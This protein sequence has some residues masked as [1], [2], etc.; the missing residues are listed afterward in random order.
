MFFWL[1]LLGLV[2]EVAAFIAVAEHIGLLWAFLLLFGV[3]LLGP[4]VVRRVGIGVLSHTQQ[5]LARGE[6]P[7]QELLDG[8]VVLMGGV[9]LCV[10]GFVGDAVGLA[11]MVS[12]LRHL[13]IRLSGRHLARRVERVN[14]GRWHDSSF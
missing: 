5:R 7:T 13:V 12:P 8:L 2:A 11:L 14:L 6:L 9:L 3:S 10:P 4:F 1:L